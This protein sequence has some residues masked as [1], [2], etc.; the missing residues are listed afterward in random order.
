[1]NYLLAT[2]LL[3][4]APSSASA[5]PCLESIETA[6]DKTVSFEDHLAVH[7]RDMTCTL[8]KNNL[9]L[10]AEMLEASK[11]AYDCKCKHESMC[12]KT[13]LEIIRQTYIGRLRL[14]S[15]KC[16]Q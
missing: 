16:S 8:E 9:R 15:E 1:M 11:S 2:L 6:K 3:L 12:D 13:N 14:H 7:Q 5:S 4:A 10:H